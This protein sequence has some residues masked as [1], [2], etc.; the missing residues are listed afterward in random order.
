M[1]QPSLPLDISSTFI[2]PPG[3]SRGGDVEADRQLQHNF[4]Q[5]SW[6]RKR[7]D[8]G[9]LPVGFFLSLIP[10]EPTDSLKSQILGRKEANPS[11]EIEKD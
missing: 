1:D 2:P 4:L 5:V 11:K 8:P 7:L 6:L 3:V 9:G 10:L